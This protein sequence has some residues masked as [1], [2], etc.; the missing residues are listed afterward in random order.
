LFATR[1]CLLVLDDV[2]E[3]DVV[4]AFYGF[5]DHCRLIITSTLP[6]LFD[7]V[8]YKANQAVHYPLEKWLTNQSSGFFMPLAGGA[9]KTDGAMVVKILNHCQ[10]NPQALY[11]LSFAMSQPPNW[12]QLWQRLEDAADWEFPE[13]YPPYLMQC[14]HLSLES[15]GDQGE[16][17]LVLSVFQDYTRIPETTLLMLWEYMFNVNA[18][19]GQSLLTQ[20]AEQGLLQRHQDEQAYVRVHRFQYA[21]MEEFSDGD[22]LHGH[23]LSA[24][25]RI[26]TQGW[27]KGPNDGYFY[28]YLGI[29]L[30][31]AERRPELKALLLDFDWLDEKLKQSSLH[32]LLSDFDLLEA[33]ELACVQ[34]VLFSM[35]NDIVANKPS[36]ATI[37]LDNLW[38]MVTTEEIKE[39]QS[40]LN[41]AR[42]SIPSWE[43][44]FPEDNLD[45]L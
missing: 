8:A 34:H 23:L 43:P 36:L 20:F 41:Q 31:K 11:L 2:R 35:A 3:I 28:D 9:D 45:N 26:C 16:Y 39:I 32:A 17:Y 25:A 10:H 37:L 13:D 30:I 24:Y 6:Q 7:F 29:H 40:L 12:V 1:H 14:L 38:Q 44:P 19:A 33:P 18:Q 42:E 15:L 22:K 21:Y 5:S 4:T 27:I